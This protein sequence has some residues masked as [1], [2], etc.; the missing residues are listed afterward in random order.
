[1]ALFI[2]RYGEVGLKSKAVRRRFENALR[3]NI[4]ERF[5]LQ[6]LE[7]RI[8]LDWG[9][10]YLWTDETDKAAEILR[11]TFGIVSFSRAIE[12]SSDKQDICANAAALSKPLYKN[13]MSFR[14][15]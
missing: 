10:V 1:M 14:V 15:R 7:C 3:R 11:K 12:C 2:I 13:G 5:I 8:E 9:R 4:A 6:K